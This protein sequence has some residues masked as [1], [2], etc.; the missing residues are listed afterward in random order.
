MIVEIGTAKTDITPEKPVPLAGFAVRDNK[1][2]DGVQS[3]LYLRALYMRQRGD[4]GETRSAVVVSADLLWWGSD[5][6]P[7]IRAKLRERFGL[8]PGAILLNATHSHSGPQTSFRFHRLLGRADADYV[9]FLENKLIEAVG[10]AA[11]DAE[12]ATLERGSGRSA[13]GVQR[14]KYE[15]GRVFGGPN[16]DGP[17]DPE[18]TVL[19]VRGRSGA[20]KAVVVHYACH[21]VTTTVNRASSEFTGAAMEALERRLGGGAVCLFLQGAC[22]DINIF[23]A[24]APPELTDD[25]AIIDYFGAKLADT[26][27][28][29]LDGGTEPVKPAALQWK[30]VSVPLRLKPLPDRGQLER[31]AAKGEPPYDEWAAAMLAMLDERTD[32]LTLEMSRLDIGDGLSLLAMNAEVVVEYGLF[33]KRISGNAV[34]PVPYSNGMIGYVPTK[35][36][37]GYG[38]YEPVLS[39]YYF[40]MPSTFD[41][42]VEETV[43]GHME[44]I[45]HE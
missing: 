13:I 26:V 40:H 37:I 41:E 2:M 21:P 17:M 45:V 12:P 32:K 22:G 44:R 25:Y 35:E 5:R 19:R 34:L 4:D 8:E 30:T 9:E 1:P 31:T 3:R 20:T 33:L 24:S 14:R 38:G 36:Q 42:S 10:Q 11:A 18:V 7:H 28:D 39:T 6:V 29:V 15:N 23:K 16:L 43:R 27:A